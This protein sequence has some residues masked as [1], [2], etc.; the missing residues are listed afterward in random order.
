MTGWQSVQ[1]RLVTSGEEALEQCAIHVVDHLRS[2][3]Y[4]WL[5]RTDVGIKREERGK[6]QPTVIA[7]EFFLWFQARCAAKAC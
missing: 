3:L 7:D 1:G 5:G 6:E 2:T 4:V